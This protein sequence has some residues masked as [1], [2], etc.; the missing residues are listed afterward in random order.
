ME[1][2]SLLSSTC[3]S[4][5]HERTDFP[6]GET[7]D[8]HQHLIAIL[9]LLS[10]LETS[11]C[12]VADYSK[13]PN[14]VA[15]GISNLLLPTLLVAPLPKQYSPPML[16]PPAIQGIYANSSRLSG[17]LPDT[18]SVVYNHLWYAHIWA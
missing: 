17:S 16:I 18:T 12:L 1:P 15:G 4:F 6:L 3:I 13:Y 14:I 7:R 8:L 5:P 2:V 11:V 10:Q 9:S